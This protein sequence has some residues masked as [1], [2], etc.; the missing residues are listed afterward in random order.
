MSQD[1]LAQAHRLLTAAIIDHV[2]PL[3]SFLSADEATQ[4]WPKLQ[5]LRHVP[6]IG[7]YIDPEAHQLVISVHLDHVAERAD[8][9][10][11]L[12]DVLA[13]LPIKIKY[14]KFQAEAAP[15]KRERARPLWGGVRMAT[16]RG[17]AGT[18]TLVV[19]KNG[20][21][22]ALVSGHV[23]GEGVIGRLVGQPDSAQDNLYGVATYNPSEPVRY[24]DAALTSIDRNGIL[25]ELDRIWREPDQAYHVTAK[26]RANQLTVGTQVF[27]QGQRSVGVSA[28]R[29]VA[30]GVVSRWDDSVLQ[31][32]VLADYESQP[33]DSGGAVF[34]PTARANEVIFAGIHVGTEYDEHGELRRL[35]SPWEGIARDLGL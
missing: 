25:G 24:S 32:Q 7:V 33:G 27:M 21:L 5:Q 6:M 26:A 30:T 23:I 17:D 20:A 3:S 8:H 11:V 22:Q 31:D 28:G 9:E 35:F 19:R 12:R 18:L 13:D 4:Y 14:V 1:P 16:E 15:A 2:G 34:L 10:R 29:I